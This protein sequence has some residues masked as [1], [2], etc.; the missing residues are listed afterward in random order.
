MIPPGFHV[1]VPPCVLVEA[2]RV[3]N[4]PL[5]I[6]ALVAVIV[7]VGLT[8]IVPDATGAEHPAAVL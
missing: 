2:F 6:V 1:N 7:G 3:A 5:Q 8:V 4:W